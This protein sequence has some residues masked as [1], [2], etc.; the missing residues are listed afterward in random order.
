MRNYRN[1]GFSLIEV[2]VAVLI[3]AVGVLG[4]AGMQVVSLQQNR[5]ALLRDQALQAGNDILDRIRS[6]AS[7][8]YAP[9]ALDDA[10]SSNADCLDN[11]CSS[12]E[13]KEFDIALWKCGINPFDEDDNV[14]EVCDGFGISAASL[15]GGGSSISKVGDVYNVTVEW[16]FDREGNTNNI[17][18][19][20]QAGDT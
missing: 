15:P 19:R 10:P 7:A 6:N 16:V 2:M 11:I 13:M 14:Y 18:L 17:V 8:D 12:A 9:V 4:V 5:D 20:T 3:V 1:K